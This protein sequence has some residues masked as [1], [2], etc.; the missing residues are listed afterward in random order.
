VMSGLNPQGTRVDSFKQPSAEE[1]THD[2]LWRCNSQLPARGMI[3]IFNRS[4]YEE[5]L[6]VRVHH[7]IQNEK[8][9][10]E[11]TKDI[12]ET[13]Y[14][15]IN[16]YELYLHENGILPVKFF[17]NISK[18]EQKKRLLARIDDK[19]KNWKFS[20]A[21]IA[22]RKYWDKYLSCYEEAINHTGTSHAPW[23]VIPSDKK[24]FS[25]LLISEIVIHKLKSLDLE[26]PKLDEKQLELL[27][28][29]EKLLKDEEDG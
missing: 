21:D 9:P 10:P 20:E 7:L 29:Y 8:I 27:K 3:G 25:R 26:Y 15:Q 22:E 19:A 28:T 16:D 1:L 17:L 24:W 14:R 2:Y 6:V 13:R 11:S 4:Y 23:Y 12:W 18:A 5:V